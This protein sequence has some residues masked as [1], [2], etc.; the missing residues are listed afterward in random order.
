[1]ILL[2]SEVIQKNIVDSIS[3]KNTLVFKLNKVQ[4]E[5]NTIRPHDT[6]EKMKR[7]W[8]LEN[9]KIR[10]NDEI[11]LLDNNIKMMKSITLDIEDESV[12]HN[13]NIKKFGGIGLLLLGG[14]GYLLYSS[15]GKN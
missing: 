3:K 15:R 4:N 8:V 13:I 14:L 12:E 9:E 10:L 2:K 6:N 7:R 11:D 1:M 5:L